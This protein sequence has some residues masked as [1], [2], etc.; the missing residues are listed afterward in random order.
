M[1]LPF[2]D[3]LSPINDEVINDVFVSSYD[4]IPLDTAIDAVESSRDRQNLI[5]LLYNEGCISL[6]YTQYIEQQPTRQLQNLA[7]LK[8]IQNGSL[9]T[10]KVALVYFRVTNQDHVSDM[11]NRKYLSEGNVFFF[12]GRCDEN[13][14]TA[15]YE[16]FE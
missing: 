10:F 7:M 4:V 11:L 14:I 13:A 5:D 6:L 16:L 12:H 1:I 3:N 15:R 9:K 8:I 2:Q